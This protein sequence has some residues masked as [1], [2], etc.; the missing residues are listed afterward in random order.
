MPREYRLRDVVRAID[1]AKDDSRVKAV[2]LDLDHF[3]G[4]YPAAIS[5]VA[6]ALGRVR[7]SGKPVLA[8]ATAYTDS[9][10]RLAA[11][12]SEIWMNP[13]GGSLFMGPGGSQLYYKGLI[14]KLGVNVHVYRVGK[15]QIL[16]RALYPRRFLARGEA[17]PISSST[18][19][20]S[21]SGAKAMQQGAAQGAARAIP[22]PAR[23]GR[24]LAA[25]RRHRQGQSRCR[26][27]RQA[28]RSH[29]LRQARRARSP[30]STS[31][32]GRRARST[33][34]ISTIM[35]ARNPLPT[36]GAAIGVLTVAGDIV[37]GKGGR[38]RTRPAIRSARRC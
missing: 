36:G 6:D 4:G 14:D 30:A 32:Q 24:S 20:S 38:R 23:Q 27:G 34:S 16:C 5:E 18:A 12:A 1:A 33:R 19:R 15:Y 7:A 21:I 8:Y 3:G 31:K 35:S 29:R 22:D 11:E 9:G 10:Y 28:R 17:E 25:R 2:V 37:D 26:A 13:M